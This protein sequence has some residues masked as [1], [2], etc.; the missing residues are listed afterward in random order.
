MTGTHERVCRILFVAHSMQVGGAERTLL[1]IMRHLAGT[2]ELYIAGPAGPML[3]S[4]R[5]LCRDTVILTAGYVPLSFNPAAYAR[6]VVAAL[7]NT[8]RLSRFMRGRTIDLVFSNTGVI[9]HGALAARL[10]RVP[11]VAMV[12][13]IISPAIL[14]RG[15]AR[16]LRSWNQ[17]IL[18][19]SEAVR[20]TLGAP[21]SAYQVV[22]VPAAAGFDVRA[23][24]PE[25]AGTTTNAFFPDGAPVVGV[26]G[27]VHPL[28]GQHHFLLMAA[29]VAQRIP[30]A[31]FAIVGAYQ[32]GSRYYRRLRRLCTRLGLDDRIVFT[33]FVDP[34]APVL[35]RLT[36]VAVPSSSESLSM[37]GIEAMTLGKPVV[38]FDVGGVSEVVEHGVTGYLLSFGDYGAMA[39]AVCALLEDPQAAARMGLAGRAGAEQKFNAADQLTRI[40]STLLEM[41][42]ARPRSEEKGAGL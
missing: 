32:P 18:V 30:S 33:G 1:R 41:L 8:V 14:R 26:V 24:A 28:K 4:F 5:P 6:A 40:E 37:V 16:L 36:V 39:G 21:R 13:E 12:H 7:V 3:D 31:R 20:T 9:L 11:S 17:R 22:K 38:A 19:M 42:Q 27:T 29:N 35:R 34:V 15:L 10:R 23:E 2:C 25:G